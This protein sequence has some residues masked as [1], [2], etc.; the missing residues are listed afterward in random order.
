MLLTRKFY[1]QFQLDD[2][3]ELKSNLN[4]YRNFYKKTKQILW[5]H[6]SVEKLILMLNVPVNS[7]GRVGTSVKCHGI[8]KVLQIFKSV[9]TQIC[10]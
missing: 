3:V 1:A 9:C 2:A 4:P 5:Y 10:L 6:V 8:L 7:Y